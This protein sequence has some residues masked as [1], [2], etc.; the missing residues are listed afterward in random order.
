MVHRQI[1]SMEEV[2]TSAHIP[3]ASSELRSQ[4][5]AARRARILQPSEDDTTRDGRQNP[6]NDAGLNVVFTAVVI[7]MFFYSRRMRNLRNK[8]QSAID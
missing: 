1:T 6:L 8:N 3:A 4:C 7:G 5:L 2:D